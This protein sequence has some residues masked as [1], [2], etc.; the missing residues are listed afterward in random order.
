MSYSG[1][2]FWS[3][4]YLTESESEMYRPE[5]GSGLHCDNGRL[6]AGT[7]ASVKEGDNGRDHHNCSSSIH[8]TFYSQAS[9][10]HSYQIT[11][12][13]TRDITGNIQNPRQNTALSSSKMFF[14]ERLCP[15]SKSPWLNIHRYNHQPAVGTAWKLLQLFF[16]SQ[17][18]AH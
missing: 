7:C 6:Q 9:L 11:R 3:Y 14:E 1:T 4:C 13:I 17:N 2:T 10:V 18:A 12:D 15:S 8:N 5:R 16:S